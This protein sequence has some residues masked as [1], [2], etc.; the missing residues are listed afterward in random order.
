MAMLWAGGKEELASSLNSL[1]FGGLL[2]QRTGAA[3]S[4]VCELQKV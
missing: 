2:V 1:H 4:D 3:A